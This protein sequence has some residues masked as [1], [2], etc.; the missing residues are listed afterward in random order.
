ME[1]YSPPLRFPQRLYLGSAV[2]SS[3]CGDSYEHAFRTWTR[4]CAMILVMEAWRLYCHLFNTDLLGVSE[5]VI[6]CLVVGQMSKFLSRGNSKAGRVVHCITGVYVSSS[7]SANKLVIL[8]EYVLTG[9]CLRFLIV[10][11]DGGGKCCNVVQLS[12]LRRGNIADAL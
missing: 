2:G 4:K 9:F 11:V 3:G 12:L 7:M 6:A 5:T 8:T 10:E 1:T